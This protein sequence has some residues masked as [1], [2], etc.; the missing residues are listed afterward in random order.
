MTF[1]VDVDSS[2]RQSRRRHYRVQTPL[3]TNDTTEALTCGT[4]LHFGDD[5]IPIRL[6]QQPSFWRAAAFLLRR[7]RFQLQYN[8][9][10]GKYPR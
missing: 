9:A 6:R 2:Q 8:L 1:I 7:G 10:R 4:K 3:S 5:G